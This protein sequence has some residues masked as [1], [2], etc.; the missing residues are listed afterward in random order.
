MKLLMISGDRSILQG[1]KGAFFYTLQEFSKQWERIDIICPRSGKELS[2]FP[3]V[4]F[5]PN[6]GGLLSQP[7][8][9]LKK[10]KELAALCRHDVVTVHDYPPFYNGIG[11]RWLHRKTGIPYATEIHHIVGYPVAANLTERIGAILS[12]LLLPFLL[13]RTRG[14]RVVN[15]Q[16]KSVLMSWGIPTA[17]I[18]IVPSFYLDRELLK[19]DSTIAK[20]WDIVF[21]GRLVPNKG[22]GNVLEAVSKLPKTK[23]LVIGDGPERARCERIA[24]ALGDRVR[25]TGWMRNNHDVYR[26]IQSGKIFVMNSLSEGGPRVALEAMALGIPVIATKVGVLPEVLENMV[27]GLFTTGEPENLKEKLQILLQDD[28][29]RS[30]MGKAAEHAVQRFERVSLIRRYADFLK[31]L[32]PSL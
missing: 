7:F 26:A 24:R 32:T 13:S 25:F 21:C 9:I 22:L 1:K 31:N 20:E 12:R 28:A 3:N 23:L 4:H 15:E 19:P 14:V 27:N 8:W 5:H 17:K 16:V 2:P 18:H 11:A 30:R 10:G 29:L 6:P